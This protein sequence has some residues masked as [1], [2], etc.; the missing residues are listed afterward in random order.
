MKAKTS[1]IGNA[2]IN[3][4]INGSD[5]EVIINGNEYEIVE[6]GGGSITYK[7]QKSYWSIINNARKKLIR[8]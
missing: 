8:L 3:A 6:I 2:L 7:K 4:G 5:K 1:T